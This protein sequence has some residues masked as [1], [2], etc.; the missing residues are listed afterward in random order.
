MAGDA[1][2]ARVRVSDHAGVDIPAAKC[3]RLD[4]LRSKGFGQSNGASYMIGISLRLQSASLLLIEWPVAVELK[5]A[6]RHTSAG[7]NAGVDRVGV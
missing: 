1:H 5:S 3:P 6:E 4:V 7:V 2:A